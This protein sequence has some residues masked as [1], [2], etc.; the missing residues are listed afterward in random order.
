MSNYKRQHSRQ[1]QQRLDINEEDELKTWT[2]RYGVSAEKIKE[3]V[4][5][6]GDRVSDVV[7]YLLDGNKTNQLTSR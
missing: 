5:M 6:V 3:A 4:T 1:Q 7:R 2:E